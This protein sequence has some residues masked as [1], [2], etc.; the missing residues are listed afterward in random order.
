MKRIVAPL[1]VGLILGALVSALWLGRYEIHML[2]G[3]VPLR[4]DRWT[5]TMLKLDY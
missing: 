4:F 3:M 2:K 5:G 1:A